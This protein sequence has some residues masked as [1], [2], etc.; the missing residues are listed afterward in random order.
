[1]ETFAEKLDFGAAGESTIARWLRDRGDTVLPVYEKI[2]DTGKG[3]TLF[4]PHGTLIAPDLLTW[5]GPRVTWIEAKRK[6]AWTWHR[7]SRT[8]TTGIDLRHYVDYLRVADETP[9]PVWLLFLQEGGRAKD[10]PQSPPG[11]YGQNISRL[12]ACEHH[13][14]ENW[15]RSGMVYWAIEDFRKLAALPLFP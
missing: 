4:L 5:K 10:S 13:R 11:L 3:P 12:R 9:W 1:M 2:L 15:G 6:T 7:L 8:W 14:H